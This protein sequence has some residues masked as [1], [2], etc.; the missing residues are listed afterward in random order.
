MDQQHLM[1]QAGLCVFITYLQINCARN[2]D[3]QSGRVEPTIG[4][5]QFCRSVLQD[6]M[7]TMSC[8]IICHT[9]DTLIPSSP[10]F[11]LRA[12]M[13]A[14]ISSYSFQRLPRLLMDVPWVSSE[15]KTNSDST[16]HQCHTHQIK[17]PSNTFMTQLGEHC[18]VS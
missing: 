17:T 8:C 4:S 6:H 1:A 13:T 9:H 10:C 15:G 12:A 7:A 2:I 3:S 14:I 18:E 11:S 16:H 5:M